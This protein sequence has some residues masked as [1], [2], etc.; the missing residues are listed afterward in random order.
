MS[1]HKNMTMNMNMKLESLLVLAFALVAASASLAQTDEGEANVDVDEL[2]T[3]AA[4]EPVDAPAADAAPPEAA[5]VEAAPVEAA[6]VEAAPVA[7][8]AQTAPAPQ[9]ERT[10]AEKGGMFGLGL[11]VAPKIGGGLGSVFLEGLGASFVGELELGYDLPLALPVGRELEVFATVGYTGPSTTAT[12]PA[13]DA[14][15]PGGSFEY[16][17]T[18]HQLVVNA[19]LLYRVPIAVVDWWRLYAALGVRNVWSATVVNGAAGGEPFGAYTETAFDLGAYGAVGSDFYVGPGAIL[20][21][22]QTAATWPD[23][24]VLRATSTT[25]VQLALGYRFFL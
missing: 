2:F 7:V 17:L 21:E 10:I 5:P 16:T 1:M 12:V 14:R 23:R 8:A 4:E 9:G 11:V 13:N 22:L 25:A 6:P 20:V 3:P 24:F 18:L 15:L 19:G